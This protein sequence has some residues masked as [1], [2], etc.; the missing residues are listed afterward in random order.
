LLFEALGPPIEIPLDL[1]SPEAEFDVNDGVAEAETGACPTPEVPSCVTLAAICQSDADR[2][3]QPP[4]M[5]DTFP[6]EIPVGDETVTAD[7]AMEQLGIADAT[8]IEVALP[9]DVSEQLEEG[10][11]AGTGAIEKVSIREVL[12]LWPENTLTFDTPPLDLYI[13]TG[14]ID[15][16]TNVDTQQL[17][18][19][20]KVER[21]GIVGIDLDDDGVFDVGQVAGSTEDVPVEFVEGGNK[22]FNDAVKSAAFTLVTASSGP[23]RLKAVDGDDTQVVKPAGV[24]K[25]QL[26]AKLL[27]SVSAADVVGGE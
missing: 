2:S 12:M 5:P 25:T 11:I 7:Q 6:R 26:K 15:D 27:Y 17:I 21:I 3:C 24:G 18:D 9:V 1:T 16:P 19:E 13:A 4:S 14:A 10:G 22:K 20:G 23:V 8:S